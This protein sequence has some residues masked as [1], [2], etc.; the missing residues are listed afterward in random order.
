[1]FGELESLVVVHPFQERLV[2]QLML[3]LY[4]S[5]RQAEAL[6]AYERARHSLAV[7]LGIEPGQALQHLERAILVHDRS[8]EPPTIAKS[9][10]APTAE[11]ITQRSR[12]RLVV[13]ALLVAVAVALAGVLVARGHGNT[14]ASIVPPTSV[15]A[16]IDPNTNTLVGAVPVDNLPT[17]I[18][19]GMGQVWALS[20]VGGTMSR[21]NARTLTVSNSVAVNAGHGHLSSVALGADEGW[22]AYN[23]TLVFIS[24]ESFL[25]ARILF[26]RNGYGDIPDVAADK[27]SI[28]VTSQLRR[29]V[30]RVDRASRRVDTTISAPA[31]PRAVAVAGGWVWVAGFD[32]SSSAGV[33][34]RIDSTRG[35][36]SAT[37][38]LPGIPGDLAT[39]YGAIWVTVN[40]ENAV[41]RIDPAT[42]SVVRTIQVGSGPE[43]V[44]AGEGSVWV[45]N[46]KDGT[47]SGSIQ[48]RTRS[49]RR[50]RSEGR[51]GTLRS[52][53]AESGRPCSE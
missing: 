21:I 53:A 8:L 36:V 24:P 22:V 35:T 12:A 18:A 13:P 5:G 9:T 26:E 46:A 19:A 38:P 25:F 44:A 1:M 40:S 50:S 30:I 47:V 3:A 43:A 15:V 20:S 42:G 27:G 37:I 48:R 6:Q 14:P 49:S 51:R 45:A 23:G 4:R 39:G 31:V 11:A 28:W 2:A 34:L 29:A 7:E 10:V 41:W 33:L 17:R 32:K 16:A 52:V